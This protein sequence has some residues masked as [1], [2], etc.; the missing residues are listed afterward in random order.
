MSTS[1]PMMVNHQNTRI[2]NLKQEENPH[3]PNWGSE[4]SVGI[5]SMIEGTIS[6]VKN[7]RRPHVY[8]LFA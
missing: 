3:A 1:F 6:V 4:Y 2:T 7:Q 8:S 5:T